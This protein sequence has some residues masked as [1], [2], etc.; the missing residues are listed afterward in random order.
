MIIVSCA[1][2]AEAQDMADI[3]Y[4]QLP[5]DQQCLILLNGTEFTLRSDSNRRRRRKAAEE[6]L[7]EAGPDG[8]LVRDLRTQLN[9]RGYRIGMA[10]LYRWLNADLE[11]GTVRNTGIRWIRVPGGTAR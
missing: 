9:R 7:D 1:T 3:L 6:I 5:A 4:L 2:E 11:E 8:I 10:T